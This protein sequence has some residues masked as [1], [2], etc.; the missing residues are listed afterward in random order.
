MRGDWAI[1]FYSS[2]FNR[3]IQLHRKNYQHF[4]YGFL[5]GIFNDKGNAAV[6]QSFFPLRNPS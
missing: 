1:H 6:F 3:L 2:L 4:F 5:I